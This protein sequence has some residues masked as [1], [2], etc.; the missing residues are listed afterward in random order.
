VEQGLP[1]G[2]RDYELDCPEYN[3]TVNL[4]LAWPNGLQE[5]L[6]APVAI[7]LD[8]EAED[9]EAAEEAHFR[10]FTSLG[11]FKKYVREEVLATL[12]GL[13]PEEQARELTR[14][15]LA[16]LQVEADRLRDEIGQGMQ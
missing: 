7:M 12:S 1:E 2:E 13:A 3:R 5:G 16:A 4:D 14:R 9:R 8:E 6:T 10:V 15:K 11:R